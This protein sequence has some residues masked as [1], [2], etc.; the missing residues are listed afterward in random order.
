MNAFLLDYGLF[1][2]KT[3]TLL[4]GVFALVAMIVAA[5][6][7]ARQ[8]PSERL[9]IEPL[10]ERIE[11]LRDGIEEQS[12]P[13]SALKTLHQQRRKATKE[14]S[15]RLASLRVE[16]LPP[17]VFVLDFTGDLAASATANLREEITAILQVARPQDEVL[18][19]L[20]SEGGVVHG[21]GLAASQLQRLRARRLRLTV[22]VDKVAAS[23]G[24]LMA[25]VADEIIA[26]PFAIVG[27]IGVVAQVPN[28]HRLLQKHDVDV[29][30]HTAGEYKRTLSIV[31]RNTEAG[32][33]KFREELDD[34]HALF[35]EFVAAHRPQ[36]DLDAVATG[37]HWFGSR[38]QALR[39][40]DQLLTSD[41]W[42]LQRLGNAEVFGL[43]Y[44][45]RKPLAERLQFSLFKILGKLLPAD[46]ASA[47][48]RTRFML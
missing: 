24:Y 32:R 19:R 7:E 9:E 48:D 36:L 15:R 37:E 11:R 29:E 31:G 25:C 38:A 34:T 1:A 13:E 14:K 33:R 47:A 41:D 23:G 8:L 27:S 3:L 18:L 6:R 17:R 26:A 10:G 44:R 39:L 30:V 22:A 4:L 2:A 16:D 21:Y 28:V 35:K 43:R 45:R 42:L 20:E 5:L 46:A 40:V 12:L